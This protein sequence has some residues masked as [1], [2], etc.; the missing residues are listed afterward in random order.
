MFYHIFY[1]LRDIFFGFNVFKYITL[2]SAGAF[3]FSFLGVV[4]FGKAFIARLKNA[5]FCERIKYE[6]APFLQEAHSS[7]E[8]TP[9]MGGIIVILAS[10]ASII[11]WA[12]LDNALI[13][14]S[15]MVM[16][17]LFL[18][19]IYDDFIKINT[20]RK[21]LSKRGKLI[22]QAGVGIAVGLYALRNAYIGP[23]LQVP[24]LKHAVFLGGWYV[25]FCV[26]VVMG[27]SNA[28]NLTDGLDGLAAG[29]MLFVIL[30]LG[31]L[32]YITGNVVFSRYL[33]LPYVGGAGELSVF[34][35]ALLGGVLGFLWFNCY[36]AQVFLGDAGAL[37]LGGVLGCISILTKKEILLF[38]AGGVFVAETISVIIQILG[39]KL[40][41]KRV[42]K[43][44]PLHHHFQVKNLHESKIIVR[45]WIVS[46]LLA[47]LALATLKIR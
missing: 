22:I 9:T 5:G 31:L 33:F 38:V 32:S 28:V 3:L 34:L 43:L 12:R 20:P 18:A 8:G 27:S 19:G 2:R 41:K 35:S 25:M 10:A 16:F 39:W 14:I 30:V 37:S 6:D 47:V 40:F 44:A 17:I 1:P 36:P 21:G 29:S 46:S 45:F 24:F 26:L 13:W 42:F 11:L 15:L 23:T 7:K 4:V